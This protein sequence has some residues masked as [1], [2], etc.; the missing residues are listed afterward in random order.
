MSFMSK[1]WLLAVPR[2]T[3]A[4]AAAVVG[5]PGAGRLERR[6]ARGTAK[7]ARCGRAGADQRPAAAR[8]PDRGERDPGRSEQGVGAPAAVQGQGRT[9]RRSGT[10][11][12]TPPIRESRTISASTTRPSSSNIAIGCPDCVQTVTLDSPIARRRTSSGRRSSTSRARRTS[13][14]RGS[15]R[16]GRTASRW[17]S[18]SPA[19]SPGDG[20]SPFIRIAG[21][22]TVY[23]APIVA[24]GD[25]P[26][27]VDHHTNT[28]D[29]VLGIHI[30]GPSAPGPVR[31]VV[32]RPAVRQGLRRRPADR[33]HQHRRR[34]AA[35]RGARALDLRARRSTRRPTT[36]A[37]TSSA[38]PASGCSASSTARPAPTTSQS[39]GFVHLVK[40]G[41]AS[42]DASAGNTA[43]IDALRNGGDL[44]NVF[45]DFPT[46]DD[47]RH[48]AGLQPA[49][50]RPARPVDRQGRPAGAQHSVR[51]TRC[52]CSTS[53]PPGPTCS[54]ASTRQPAS[55]RPTASVGVDIN[56]AVIGFIDKAPTANLADPVA[57]LAVPA[58]LAAFAAALE[59][60]IDLGSAALGRR[61]AP[62]HG[63][64]RRGVA[65]ADQRRDLLEAH[66][67]R[68]AQV[69]GALD[70]QAPDEVVRA[71]AG[72]RAGVAL[73]RAARRPDR[74]RP[75]RRS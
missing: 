49:V 29:R 60:R 32:G 69:V 3:L 34:P 24:T 67:G 56:C 59:R 10:C 14:R 22:P 73:E 46:L 70:A 65:V 28:G 71:Q 7:R 19:R 62:K 55:P 54:P 38:P 18:S 26:F 58:A 63:P 37:T 66:P 48:C 50:G 39:Q 30:A 45:G 20:Y 35:D 1:R 47:P 23:S 31:R 64:Q 21:S 42:E 41:H 53:P 33:L 68:A 2:S 6:R 44:L 27:D 17:P 52:R 57:Q 74:A 51:S 25:G 12:S 11:C 4:A 8:S 75:R 15:P 40:D 5:S 13:A 72:A 61:S 43:L 9:A 36:A 16:R